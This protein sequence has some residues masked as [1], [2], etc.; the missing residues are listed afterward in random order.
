MLRPFVL[1][2]VFAFFAGFSAFVILSL[3]ARSE[4]S[5]SEWASQPRAIPAHTQQV[6][7]LAPPSDPWT[8]EKQI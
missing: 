1:V 8:F 4:V 3:G 6:A 7:P 2:A 5:E